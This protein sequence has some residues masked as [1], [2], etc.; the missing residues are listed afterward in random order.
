MKT[1]KQLPIPKDSAWDKKTLCLKVSYYNHS[2]A[3][4]LLFRVLEERLVF[5]W[6]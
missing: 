2:K 6:D 4:K 5:W 3:N 1:Y